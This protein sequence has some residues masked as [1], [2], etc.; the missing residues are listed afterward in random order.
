[1]T[2]TKYSAKS[3]RRIRNSVSVTGIA[4]YSN[5]G[6]TASIDLQADAANAAAQSQAARNATSLDLRFRL[7]ADPAPAA[8]W[9]PWLM[10]DSSITP[11]IVVWRN[12]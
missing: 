12:G 1:M 3:L 5:S 2:A 4:D 6:G 9:L 7:G 10:F 11:T 8:L